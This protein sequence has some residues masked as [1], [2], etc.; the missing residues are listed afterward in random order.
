MADLLHAIA[1]T[2][3]TTTLLLVLL[4]H[5]RVANVLKHYERRC[6]LPPKYETRRQ[7]PE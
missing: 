5:K 3:F 4:S 2:H 6:T 7:Y 1:Q